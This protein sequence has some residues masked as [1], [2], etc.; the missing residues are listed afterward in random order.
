MPSIVNLQDILL[1]D[2]NKEWLPQVMEVLVYFTAVYLIG[3]TLYHVTRISFPSVMSEYVFDFVKTMTICAYSIGMILVRINFGDVWFILVLVPL[4]LLTV[5]TIP[6]EATPVTIWVQYFHNRLSVPTVLIKTTVLMISGVAAFWVG[7]VV[8]KLNLHDILFGFKYSTVL[9]TMCSS[10]LNVPLY[11]GFVL[12][13][14]AVMYDSWFIVQKLSPNL[15]L[16][17]AFKI[18]NTGLLVIAGS[19]LTGM[20]MH[21][22]KASGLTFG[23]GQT[24]YFNHILVYWIGP[25]VGAWLS[26]K[27]QK[28]LRL[29]W[30]SDDVATQ[31]SRQSS[32]KKAKQ[33][34][35]K[36]HY[37]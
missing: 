36:R 24:S 17:A 30:T 25:L 12:E 33:A 10:A 20:F 35:K 34:Q 2:W 19:H 15:L 27:L 18:S 5:I 28:R 22:P 6:G 31:E 14:L 3:L 7:I 8:L 13:M 4:I 37:D 32:V 29:S 26:A 11:Q 16:D 21:P 23:C 1:T 9:P